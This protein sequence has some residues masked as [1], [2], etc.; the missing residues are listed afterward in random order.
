NRNDRYPGDRQKWDSILTVIVP[1]RFAWGFGSD[2]MHNL[3][4]DIGISWN[5]V[6]VPK[7][8]SELVRQA[9]E[10]GCFFFV[11]SPQGH[12]GSPAPV[13]EAIT[14]DAPSGTIH[15]K[16]SGHERIE[17]ISRGRI[18]RRGDRLRLAALPKQA[19]YVRAEISGA[20]GTVV[21]TQPFGITR[22]ESPD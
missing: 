6:I 8:T 20:D 18:V 17:W 22:L 7:L 11:N 15:I 21:G 16:A 9:L 1:D 4:K 3:D 19:Q 5:V 13:I 2:D 12:G 10:Q 14:V